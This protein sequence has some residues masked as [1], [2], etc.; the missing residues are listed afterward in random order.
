MRRVIRSGKW[1]YDGSVATGVRIVETDC[2]PGTGDYED[3][4][5][6]SDDRPGT[7]YYVEWS[8]AGCLTETGSS[9][10]P[11]ATAKDAEAH[12][13]AVVRG[14]AAWEPVN[15][16]PPSGSL[17]WS[18]DAAGRHWD[19]SYERLAVTTTEEQ[20]EA[21]DLDSPVWI[22][23]FSRSDGH[24]EEHSWCPNKHILFGTLSGWSSTSIKSLKSALVAALRGAG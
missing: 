3:D 16:A 1:L 9:V 14:G 5:E 18:E 8:Q 13:A 2:A 12:V 7:F 19:V 22:L 21:V 23:R 15:A 17:L 4:P 11:F 10:G 6:T 24:S 20:V